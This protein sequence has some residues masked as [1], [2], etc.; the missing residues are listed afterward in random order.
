MVKEKN[1][2]NRIIKS[3]LDA[4][5]DEVKINYAVLFG[6]YAKG[7]PREESDIDIAII[8][9]DFGINRLKELQYLSRMRRYSDSSIEGHPFSMNDFRN[10]EKGDFLSH[11][12]ET[13]IIIE[14]NE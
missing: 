9:K 4:V 3:Y 7:N 13:G 8:S 6:S 1:E 10:R 11:I 2:V 5:R 14:K 12:F